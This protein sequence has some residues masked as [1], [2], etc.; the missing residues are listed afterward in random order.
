M[1]SRSESRVCAGDLDADRVYLGRLFGAAVF[2]ALDLTA[3]F[4]PAFAVE[5]DTFWPPLALPCA[6]CDAFAVLDGA[7]AAF[8]SCAAAAL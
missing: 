5:V 4:V 2:V 1:F 7:W 8:C 3:V 6:P